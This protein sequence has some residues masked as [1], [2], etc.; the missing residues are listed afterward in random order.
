MKEKRVTTAN[1]PLLR[2]RTSGGIAFEVNRPHLF[3]QV[4]VKNLKTTGI[5]S[6][7]SVTVRV[8]L[9][10]DRGTPYAESIVSLY[11]VK[12]LEDEEGDTI[13][14]SSFE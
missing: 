2:W 10:E 4:W 8:V 1:T 13:Y 12:S 3:D 11:A 7:D 6:H 9:E 14:I 5:L